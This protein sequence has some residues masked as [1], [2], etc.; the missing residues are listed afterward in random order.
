MEFLSSGVSSGRA[1]ATRHNLGFAGRK[2]RGRTEQEMLKV[3]Q[4]QGSELCGVASRLQRESERIEG[5]SSSA[6]NNPGVAVQKN[7]GPGRFLPGLEKGVQLRATF[8]G[9]I[10]RRADCA[11]RAGTGAGREFHGDIRG[12]S[13]LPN[14]L[15]LGGKKSSRV[16]RV[17]EKWKRRRAGLEGAGRHSGPR[18][19]GN[20]KGNGR[21]PDRHRHARLHGLETFLHRQHSRTGGPRSALPCAGG[22]RKRTRTSLIKI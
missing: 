12:D 2:L 8:R 14:G 4:E 13:V 11:L 16:N 18:D 6:A 10:W 7:P 21:G 19:R 22:A 20:G 3:S 5:K 17:R 15:F 9:G 1:S